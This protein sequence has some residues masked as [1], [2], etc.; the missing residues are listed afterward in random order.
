[1]IQS[2]SIVNHVSSSI[3]YFSIYLVAIGQSRSSESRSAADGRPQ[4]G[5]GE[6]RARD[7]RLLAVRHDVRK[8]S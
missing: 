8:L 4:D 7:G 3:R 1:M 5:R 6:Q 2:K